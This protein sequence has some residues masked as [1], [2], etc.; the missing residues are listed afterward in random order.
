MFHSQTDASKVALVALV[1]RLTTEGVGLID[2]QVASEHLL[3]LGGREIPRSSFLQ[4]LKTGVL[5]QA[6]HGPC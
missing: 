5:D 2:C 6:R 3:R 4:F 1:Q